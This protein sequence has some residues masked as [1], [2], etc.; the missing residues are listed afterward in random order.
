[1][2]YELFWQNCTVWSVWH[3][4]A[5]RTSDSTTFYAPRHKS[6]YSL[7]SCHWNN[8][9]NE[10]IILF[11]WRK[12][13]ILHFT[14]RSE[15]KKR[16]KKKWICMRFRTLKLNQCHWME[17]CLFW[18]EIH[19]N[20]ILIHSGKE[21]KKKQKNRWTTLTVN[22]IDTYLE[23]KSNINAC[24]TSR[25]H[26]LWMQCID[27]QSHLINNWINEFCSIA[28]LYFRCWHYTSNHAIYF[29]PYLL[30]WQAPVWLLQ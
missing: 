16:K 5:E 13:E 15:E 12:C 30:G 18:E 14:N 17:Q 1:M 7:A 25:C 26:A 9:P 19:N 8:N 4:C 11:T 29:F 2:K 10:T 6:L 28:P 3:I 20:G 27:V 22:V 24:Q 23:F 21:V